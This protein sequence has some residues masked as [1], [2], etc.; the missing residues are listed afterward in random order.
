MEEVVKAN[1][2][3]WFCVWN[4][5]QETLTDITEPSEMAEKVLEMWLQDKPTR[6]GANWLCS[7]KNEQRARRKRGKVFLL[8]DKFFLFDNGECQKSADFFVNVYKV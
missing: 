5:P 7:V 3:S 1:L 8:N 2:R 4:N 6:T